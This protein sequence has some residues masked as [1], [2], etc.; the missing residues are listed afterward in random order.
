MTTRESSPGSKARGA[1][2]GERSSPALG[3]VRRWLARLT[4]ALAATLLVLLVSC[5][6]ATTAGA[7]DEPPADVQ[8][9]SGLALPDAPAGFT[10]RTVGA[11]TFE[12][13][14]LAAAAL[15][16]LIDG[17][18]ASFERVCRELGAD[19]SEPLRVRVGRSPEEMAALAPEGAP[20]P[21]Y[22]VGV[23]YP[24]LNLVLLT[25]SAPDT[26]ERPDL[27]R[28]F[29]HELAH[30]ATHRATAGRG[31]PRWLDEGIAIHVAGERSL[32]R[33]QV[34]W[35]GT[36]GGRLIALDDLSES[37]P[38]RSTHVSLAYAESADFVAWI[39]RRSPDGP[40]KLRAMLGRISRGQSFEEAVRQ[41]WSA[42]I[43]Q[44]ELEWRGALSE[45][46]GMLPL[47]L[48]SGL[49][50]G[51]VGIL[52]VLAWARRRRDSRVTLER[53]EREEALVARERAVAEMRRQ[54]ALAA[55]GWGDTAPRM[56][57]D[58]AILAV[59]AS[60]PALAEAAGSDAGGDAEPGVAAEGD[61][62]EDSTPPPGPVA[63]G[64]RARREEDLPT[65]E[66]EGDRH[67]L[68]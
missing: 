21:G 29:V 11:V 22:A 46:Y 20:P 41:T 35:E 28:V 13:H 60:E 9:V 63:L 53:W 50:W 45:R 23:A 43:G 36:V 5:A 49:A 26:W 39:L 15:A 33:V 44:L 66:W 34:L 38:A 67:T 27:E 4:A 10:T 31:V 48:G 42:G 19:A 37:F 64:A 61:G 57:D 8:R 55:L 7:Q 51:L 54:E 68:H 16:S 62:S 12:H 40:D 59:P 25:L 2:Q 30:V 32:E 17:A 52:V 1:R 47:L 6:A 14:G 56:R 18:G 24:A 3:S 65:V 58:G